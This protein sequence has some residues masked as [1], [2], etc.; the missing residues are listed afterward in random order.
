M[1]IYEYWF[2]KIENSNIKNLLNQTS[3]YPGVLICFEGPNPKFSLHW[4][5]SVKAPV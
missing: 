5:I 4:K 2:N 1:K 3:R